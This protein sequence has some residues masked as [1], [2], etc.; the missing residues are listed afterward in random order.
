FDDADLDVAVP[1]AAWARLLN[2][3]QV[4]TSAKRVYLAAPIA[5]DFTERL[6]EYVGTLRVGDPMDPSVDLGPLISEEAV[7]T[8]EGQIDEA[9]RQGARVLAG[10]CRVQPNGLRGHFLA[11]T[12]L[13]DVAH[14]SLPTTEEIFGPVISLTVARDAD[15]AIRM[16]ND[17]RYGLGASVYTKS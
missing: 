4:C 7:A 2:A 9:A 16:A 8:V 14:G 3:G 10:G 15:D 6:L 13:G 1:G 17:S 12:I 5:R 11:P